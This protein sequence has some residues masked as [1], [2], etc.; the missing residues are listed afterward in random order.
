LAA[1]LLLLQKFFHGS[2]DLDHLVC[3]YP[4]RKGPHFR[5]PLAGTIFFGMKSSPGKSRLVFSTGLRTPEEYGVPPEPS[6]SWPAGTQ[7]DPQGRNW[8]VSTLVA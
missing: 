1:S 5:D 3:E 4:N 8:P 6:L 7:D 2:D